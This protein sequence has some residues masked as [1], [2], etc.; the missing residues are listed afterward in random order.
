M[1]LIQLTDT[2][3]SAKSDSRLYGA[4]WRTGLAAVLA[5]IRTSEEPV[6]GLLLTGDLAHDEGEAAYRVLAGLLEPATWPLY[7]LPG[8]HDTPEAMHLVGP[9]ASPPPDSRWQIRLL[10]SRIAGETGGRLGE[11]QIAALDTE[12]TADPRH[13]LVCVHHQPVPVGSAWLDRIGLADGDELLAMLARHEN[14]RGLVW[15][16]VHQ[17]F[18]AERSG[19]R[20]M[21]TPSTC[22]Q[23]LP[24]SAD[25]AVDTRPPGYRVL[26]LW[27]DGRIETEVRWVEPAGEE[28]Q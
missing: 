15:G 4:D 3:V 7:Y 24:G 20:L 16:H 1:R 6:D 25:F 5:Q 21:A 19:V 8:N 9:Q 23:F 26:E 11:E 2:H 18:D 28:A 27:P 14:V 10:D 12:L 22:I 13:A 17:A